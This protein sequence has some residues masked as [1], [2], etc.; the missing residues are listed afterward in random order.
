MR[1]PRSG[2]PSLATG[3]FAESSCTRPSAAWKKLDGNGL[4][5]SSPT[6][7]LQPA[8]GSGGAELHP[9]TR[10]QTS[11]ILIEAELT[12]TSA[13]RVARRQRHRRAAYEVVVL[14]A[15]PFLDAVHH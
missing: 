6:S 14:V 13:Q 3:S 7:G 11:R 8:A 9:A 15:L 1:S 12:P 4:R 10:T 5:Q 2:V